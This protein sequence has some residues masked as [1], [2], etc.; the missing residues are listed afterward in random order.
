MLVHVSPGYD[1]LGQVR[2]GLVILVHISPGLVRLGQVS[3]G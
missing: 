3:P 2:P 1:K